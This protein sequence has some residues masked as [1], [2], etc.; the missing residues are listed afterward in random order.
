[1]S[2]DDLTIT[3]KVHRVGTQ[4]VLAISDTELIGKVLNNSGVNFSVNRFFYE[5]KVV[6]ERELIS[7]M[8]G[9][10]NINIIGDRSVKVALK[11]KMVDHDDITM[12]QGHPH[13]QI[14]KIGKD[15]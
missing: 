11:I 4:I 1:M 8:R 3:A 15:V 6:T 10:S 12:V 2:K 7:L 14:Y 9:S 13:V 5:G